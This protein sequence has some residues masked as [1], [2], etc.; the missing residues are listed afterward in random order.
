MPNSKREQRPKLGIKGTNK[1]DAKT[2]AEEMFAGTADVNAGEG[3]VM[4]IQD[5]VIP[6]PPEANPESD[7]PSV[8]DIKDRISGLFSSIGTDALPDTQY[9][10]PPKNNGHEAREFVVA[11][12]LKKL[13]EKRYEDAKAAADAAGCFGDKSTYVAGETIEVYRSPSFTFSIQRNQNSVMLD[14]D[15]T[16]QVLRDL[17]PA[18]WTDF[19]KMCQKPKAGATQ[20]IV[21]LK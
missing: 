3:P 14:K 18:K 17:S 19:L 1:P 12:Q 2:R 4:H 11:Q 5:A 10:L 6:L 16:T 13:A 8:R 9:P 20:V 21:A 15:Q 7:N